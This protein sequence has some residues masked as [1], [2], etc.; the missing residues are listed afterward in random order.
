MAKIEATATIVVLTTC[1]ECGD[2]LDHT[3]TTDRWGNNTLAVEFC[4]QCGDKAYDKGY[5]DG[6][7]ATT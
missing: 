4:Q 5:D 1:A 2:D 6:A 3:L 7:E